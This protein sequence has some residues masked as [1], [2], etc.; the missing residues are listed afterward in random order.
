[1]FY[2]YIDVCVS[3]IRPISKCY[4][5]TSQFVLLVL[6]LVLE[7]DRSL[8]CFSHPI[9]RIALTVQASLFYRPPFFRRFILFLIG[10]IDYLL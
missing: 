9:L 3:Y 1:M 8:T 6:K 5:I 7:A 2:V 10:P 4:H